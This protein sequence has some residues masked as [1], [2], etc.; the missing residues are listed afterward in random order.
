VCGN[1]QKN[2]PPKARIRSMDSTIR[3]Q[4]PQ[5]I[6]LRTVQRAAEIL[7][8]SVALKRHLG[9]P[10]THVSVWMHGMVRVPTDIFLRCVDIVLAADSVATKWTRPLRIVGRAR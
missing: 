7:G 6:H 3:P 10:M 2:K 8:G 4:S 1:Q 9:V 5:A